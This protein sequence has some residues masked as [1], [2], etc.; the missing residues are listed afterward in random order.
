MSTRTVNKRARPTAPKAPEL[1]VSGDDVLELMAYLLASAELCMSEPYHYGSFRL[2]DGASRLAG[3]ALRG[4]RARDD[5]WLGALKREIDDHK[6]LLMW[7]REGY[8]AYLHEVTGK[9]AEHIKR[10]TPA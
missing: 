4:G 8:V 9:V 10:E 2:L 3:Y 6:G 1:V 5:A 7:D